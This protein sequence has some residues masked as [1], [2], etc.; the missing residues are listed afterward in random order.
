MN[1]QRTAAEEPPA[2][3]GTVLV[4]ILLVLALF[5]L[6]AAWWVV[7]AGLQQAGAAEYQR[8]ITAR[9]A[10]DSALEHAKAAVAG[11]SLLHATADSGWIVLSSSATEQV[12][13]R[14]SVRDTA[15][16]ST[17]ELPWPAVVARRASPVVRT[18][19]RWRRIT[20]PQ[21]A[22]HH[23]L[24]D[25][26]AAALQE[27]AAE[28]AHADALAV[29]LADA[30]DD[31]LAL[32]EHDGTATG[33]EGLTL[34][35]ARR[36]D[37]RI[38][39][40]AHIMRQ[41]A[42]YDVDYQRDNFAIF[43]AF[44]I[45]EVEP[46]VD[47]AGTTNTR[48]RLAARLSDPVRQRQWE[49]FQQLW[50]E[51]YPERF[52]PHVWR[53]QRAWLVMECGGAGSLLTILDNDGEWLYFAG[54]PHAACVRGRYVSINLCSARA[55][56]GG[57]T[58]AA[59]R[60]PDVWFVTGLLA[61]AHY[62][63]QWYADGRTVQPDYT[64]VLGSAV[65]RANVTQVQP[66]RGAVGLNVTLTPGMSISTVHLSQPDM[67]AWRYTGV[68][69]LQAHGWQW[70][71]V[72]PEH[73]M[74][75]LRIVSNTPAQA[76]VM[77]GM[78]WTWASGNGAV[79][80]Q[81]N[82]IS[83][84][85]RD[86]A[87][88]PCIVQRTACVPSPYGGWAWRITARVHP[89]FPW[90]PG[91]WRGAACLRAA[92][93]NLTTR[94]AFLV[95][96]N[97]RNTLLVHAGTRATADAY[98]PVSGSMLRIGGVLDAMR[99]ADSAL[100][101][102]FGQ[103]C[104][105]FAPVAARPPAG[106]W[107]RYEHNRWRAGAPAALAGLYTNDTPA[108]RVSLS[109][110]WQRLIAR[111]HDRHAL[112]ATLDALIHPHGIDLPVNASSAPS[113]WIATQ[114]RLRRT[115]ARTWQFPRASTHWPDNFWRGAEVTFHDTHERAR[116]CASHGTSLEL[117]HAVRAASGSEATLAP[118]AGVVF[119]VTANEAADG[120]WE[121]QVPPDACGPYELYL[122]GFCPP[123]SNATA[124]LNVA[125]FNARTKAFEPLAHEA[126]FDQHDLIHA[127]VVREEH[128]DARR[129]FV[130]RITASG[131]P[132]W[133]RG[134]YL[135][136]A[137]R[138]GRARHELAGLVSDA[139]AA[140]VAARVVRNGAVAAHREG[141]ALLVRAWQGMPDNLTPVVQCERLV[142]NTNTQQ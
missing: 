42:F 110:A 29:A 54:F 114:I 63:L 64:I 12:H 101:N 56:P 128:L 3:R 55:E 60:A 31:N 6:V 77:P 68:Q 124:R 24:R 87:G 125:V 14:I 62:R 20:D 46:V 76:L 97:T 5:S 8:A 93:S 142:W 10:V 41:S 67:V 61:H 107:L 11:V 136:P 83:F 40:V 43:G 118:L 86:E 140:H 28:A 13:Y 111:A 73:I 4:L 108:A 23:M 51:V 34:A 22:S 65:Q 30:Y 102:P 88:L 103:V 75:A 137:A 37:E 138:S 45:D 90:T 92:D 57:L 1:T 18:G 134:V 81:S 74:D 95:I 119:H 121:W 44:T 69:P 16:I 99:R 78:L 91:A 9:T 15:T 98:A 141:T 109:P 50:H 82:I 135:A 52:I 139:F 130:L 133:V 19:N 122:R 123:C 32:A 89:D 48:V 72:V 117:D 71:R 59:P 26:C 38:V 104:A 2:P 36:G 27:H 58:A 47:D 39:P 79:S 94:S 105:R 127:G 100:V 132:A 49:A 85:P 113:G 35:G 80:I 66:V 112:A 120:T 129:R 25:A 106:V 131:A 84:V 53:G 116:V 21:V 7:R 115:G 17:N 126:V 33:F 96:D 70:Q